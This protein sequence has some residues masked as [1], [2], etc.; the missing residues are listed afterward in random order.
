VLDVVIAALP[1]LTLVG[2]SAQPAYGAHYCY[3]PPKRWSF[4]TSATGFG[5]LGYALPAAI[6]AKLASSD[7]P[8]T[9]LIGDGDCRSLYR[10]GDGCRGSG[11]D[12][13]PAVEQPWL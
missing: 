6:G 5:T 11:T 10:I 4:W 7:R 9:S 3:D 1:D 13:H 2:D 8:V 12:H